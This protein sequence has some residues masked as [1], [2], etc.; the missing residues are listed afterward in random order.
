MN[1]RLLL[2]VLLWGRMALGQVQS[3]LNQ[4]DRQFDRLSFSKAAELYEEALGKTNSLTEAQRRSALVQLAYSYRQLNDMKNAERA[5]SNLLVNG[6]L[7]ADLSQ[8]Y[9]Y[10]A[11]ALA[12]NGKYEAAQKAYSRYEAVQGKS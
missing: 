12:S 3:T 11:Q 10:Y 9:L 6:E 1:R 2:L 8:H 7:P 4:A 5:Y